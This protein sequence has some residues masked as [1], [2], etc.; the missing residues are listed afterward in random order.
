[1][2][3]RKYSTLYERLVANTEVDGNGCW[4]WTG[5]VKAGYPRIAIRKPG[6]SWPRT[7]GAHRVMLEEY[8]DITFPHDEAAHL[9]D[10]SMCINPAHLEVQTKCANMADRWKRDAKGCM[11][12]VLYPRTE[13]LDWDATAITSLP[14]DPCPF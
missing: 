3:R 1:M 5:T 2:A 8:H 13:E 11:I 10:N 6:K 14:G 12:P 7:F 9:C 4:V